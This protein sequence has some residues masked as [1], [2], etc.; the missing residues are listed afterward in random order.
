[1]TGM[2]LVVFVR[3]CHSNYFLLKLTAR[4]VAAAS[5]L[6]K[7]WAR[8]SSELRFFCNTSRPLS[9]S[10]VARLCAGAPHAPFAHLASFVPNPCIFSSPY[11]AVNWTRKVIAASSLIKNWARYSTKTRSTGHDPFPPTFSRS[12]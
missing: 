2:T 3:S 7:I 9:S 8:Q 5:N 12:A 1:M 10:K 6:F 11:L 4:V